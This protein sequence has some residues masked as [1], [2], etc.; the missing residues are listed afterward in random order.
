MQH[1]G[2]ARMPR[3]C[4]GRGLVVEGDG[5]TKHNYTEGI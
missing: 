1:P 2:K 4:K 5:W 3:T